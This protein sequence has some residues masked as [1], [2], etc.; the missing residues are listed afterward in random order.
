MFKNKQTI[1]RNFQNQVKVKDVKR[2]CAIGKKMRIESFFV[3]PLFPVQSSSRKMCVRQLRKMSM[4]RRTFSSIHNV[5]EK[6]NKKNEISFEFKN[7][8]TKKLLCC[9]ADKNN[10]ELCVFGLDTC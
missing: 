10:N 8:F 5:K 1:R 9:A 2:N 7:K 3:T 6:R 4:A